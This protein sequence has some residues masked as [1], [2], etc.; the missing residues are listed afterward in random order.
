MGVQQMTVKELHDLLKSGED[1]VLLDCR[2]QQEWDFCRIDGAVHIPMNQVG[3]RH[4]ELDAANQIVI[5]CHHGIRSAAVAEF[6]ARRGFPNVV[7]LEG[8]IDAWSLEVDP[9]VPRY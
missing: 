1:P 6:L 7:N 9:D 5:Y 8:G 3:A 2:E 4:H